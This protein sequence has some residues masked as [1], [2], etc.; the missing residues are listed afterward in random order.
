[1]IQLDLITGQWSSPLELHLQLLNIKLAILNIFH[2][3]FQEL[4]GQFSGYKKFNKYG[5][6]Q[7]LYLQRIYAGKLLLLLL[8]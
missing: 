7:T 4:N 2:T 1:M 5:F 3:L 8:Y 6:Q